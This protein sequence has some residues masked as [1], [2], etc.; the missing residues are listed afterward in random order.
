MFGDLHQLPTR[1]GAGREKIGPAA[2]NTITRK[3]ETRRALTPIF[4]KNVPNC[5]S[6]IKKHLMQT[7]L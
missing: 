2:S 1:Q 6:N 7:N 3:F 5:D 4:Y